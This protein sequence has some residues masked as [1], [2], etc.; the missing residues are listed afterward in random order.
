MKS[1]LA[2]AGQ[3]GGMKLRRGRAG[4]LRC[5]RAPGRQGRSLI[6][7]APDGKPAAASDSCGGC[8]QRP[9][10]AR[11]RDRH[12][13]R[14]CVAPVCL[15]ATLPMDWSAKPAALHVP[16]AA[17]AIM[18][19]PLLDLFSQGGLAALQGPGSR[20]PHLHRTAVCSST[21]RSAAREPR[22]AAPTLEGG[23]CPGPSRRSPPQGGAASR[24]GS[25]SY[26]ESGVLAKGTKVQRRRRS[27]RKRA[28]GRA[29]RLA[30][31]QAGDN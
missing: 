21:R 17:C 20:A 27:G 31:P 24:G 14:S 4:R 18:H 15:C 25:G 28:A 8:L 13:R 26:A 29:G 5:C 9:G 7:F 1:R 12:R 23:M 22:R 11:P 10:G 16:I 19:W 6:A 3:G 30:P 2:A